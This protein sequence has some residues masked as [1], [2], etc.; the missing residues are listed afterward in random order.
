MANEYNF[1]EI[2]HKAGM[3]ITPQRLAICKL[4]TET[5][6]HPTANNIY[7][8]LKKQYPSLSLATVY[9]T[10]DVLVAIGAVNMLGS[11]GDDKVHFD[12]NTI[13]HINLACVRCHKIVDVSSDLINQMDT[14]INQNS[15]YR[16]LGSRVLYYG[17]CPE[18]QKSE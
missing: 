7:L 10:L 9:N 8:E 16:L 12:G 17:I 15:G 4:I 2:L 18:C 11:I 5:D 3:R 6:S 1:V 14:E 13:P